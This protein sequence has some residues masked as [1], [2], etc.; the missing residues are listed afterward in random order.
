SLGLVS[1]R[2]EAE[3]LAALRVQL[4]QQVRWLLVF[5]NAETGAAMR[6]WLPAGV[7]HVLVTSRCRDWHEFASVA[8]LEPFNRRESLTLLRE[9]VPDLPE[10]DADRIADQLGDLPL[11]L[12]QAATVL[13]GGMPA[14]V[15]L[16]ML[17]TAAAEVLSEGLPT[18]YP[19]S[20]AG[21]L[22]M[23]IE[24][25]ADD[26]GAL[27]LLGLC[28]VLAPEPIP[29]TLLG[30]GTDDLLSN[31]V[32]Q[33]RTVS[34]LGEL[35]RVGQKGIQVHRLVQT[36]VLSQPAAP[37]RG[38]LCGQAAVLVAASHPG[39]PAS[40]A[41][42]PGWTELMPHLLALDPG[43]SDHAGLRALA[44]DAMLYLLYS[45]DTTAGLRLAEH[46]YEQWRDKLG[47]DDPQT[48]TAGAELAHAYHQ[49]GR[50]REAFELVED[51]LTRRTAILG[52]DDPATLRS[53]ND[54]AVVLGVFGRRDDA[55]QQAADVLA[56]RT[57]TLGPDHPD[58]L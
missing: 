35:A 31:P 12:V 34:R 15:Y 39:D 52:P 40:A 1:E 56:R 46:L 28:C 11:A 33:Y 47:P 37:V 43:G 44:C 49:M 3:A 19:R 45:G 9:R 18:S 36:L 54:R 58:T 4:Q 14:M 24:A 16:Q 25:L 23:S 26:A 6:P 29:L 38:E 50:D 8:A 22:R 5:D 42:W 7:G 32:A 10:C 57:A 51:T 13:A 48:L 2:A 41:T 30:R 55:L 27:Y 20:L 53:A 17:D 21:A